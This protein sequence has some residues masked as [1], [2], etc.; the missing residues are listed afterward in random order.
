MTKTFF[1]DVWTALHAP[2]SSWTTYNYSPTQKPLVLQH[3]AE[4]WVG[5]VF[6]A[7]HTVVMSLSIFWFSKMIATMRRHYAGSGGK[8]KAK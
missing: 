2:R 7:T 5:I 3:Q 8:R 6:L 1:G 4:W